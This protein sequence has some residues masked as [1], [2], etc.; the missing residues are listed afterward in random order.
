MAR[1][2]FNPQRMAVSRESHP[3]PPGQQGNPPA[4][5]AA[6]TVS[7]LARL[8]KDALAA[9]V[10][11]RVRVV[12]EVSNLSAR[13]HW[14]FSLKDDA[15]CLRCVMFATA[16]RK[17]GFEFHDGMQVVATGRLDYY[18]AQGNVQ[19][20]VEKVE[21]VGVGELEM[22]YRALCAELRKK[23][24]FEADRKK[25]LP[26]MPRR[27]AVVTSRTGAALQDVVN[28]AARRWRGCRLLLLDVHVQGAS[29]AP[30]IAA[31]IDALS[32]Q[33]E[34]HGIDAIILTRGGGSI[35]DLW[36]FN[37]RIVA[38]AV[39]RCRL[40]IVAAI[41]HET[42]TTIAEL[43]ADARCATPTQAAMTLIPDR[44]AVGHQVDQLARR[45]VLLV[46]RHVQ[47]SRQRLESAARH[48]IFRRPVHL[49]EPH[50][51]RL[52]HLAQRLIADVP[53][54]LTAGRERVEA[55]RRQLEALGPMNVLQRGYTYTLGPDGRVLR[56]AADVAPDDRITTVLRDGRVDSRVEGKAGRAPVRK[57]SRGRRRK[58]DD[59]PSLF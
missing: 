1:L 22:R 10:P 29:A 16:A 15:S 21:P 2:P 27:V 38:D 52:D 34:A 41:G 8:I 44:Q 4:P 50:R 3:A 57:E 20:Y 7:Q 43:V 6:L 39:F 36:A 31:A 47:H 48:P 45:L 59:G 58:G 46:S 42:D 17:V 56:H 40:P 33:G 11:G 37:E 49:V 26:A 18:D 23:G 14:F 30:E 55:L 13:N 53:R 12:G 51:R 19:L 32:H 25:R 24:Y 9:H 28:T 35:E 5:P 54:R